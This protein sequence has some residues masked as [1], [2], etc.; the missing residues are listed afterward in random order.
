MR[1]RPELP[2]A[3]KGV[4]FIV[5]GGTKVGVVGRTGSGKSSLMMLLMRLYEIE[6]G[7]ISVD[8]VDI[9]QLSLHA[10]R[11]KIG[12]V[13]QDPVLFSGTLRA[14]L[15][16]F[17]Q[18]SDDEILSALDA[19]SLRHY[20]ESLH[21]GLQHKVQEF[22]SNFSQGQRQLICLARV[23]LKK[24]AILLLD[25]ATSSV[26]SETDALLQRVIA[27]QFSNATVLTIAHR[28]NTVMGSDQIMVS[29]IE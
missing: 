22:G 23:L 2:P 1:Y 13:P 26:D 11:S 10:L 17:N 6:K 5:D 24:P 20:T 12:I 7:I 9:S 8:G 14:N 28:L 4:S 21:D 15:D 18:Y 16:P 25:E 27:T 29:R 3:L 19:V